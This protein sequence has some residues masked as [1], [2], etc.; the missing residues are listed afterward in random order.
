MVSPSPAP[1]GEGG[2]LCTTIEGEGE[3][4]VCLCFEGQL[5]LCTADPTNSGR[6]NKGGVAAPTPEVLH[7]THP[8]V[9]HPPLCTARAPL[10]RTHPPGNASMRTSWWCPPLPLSLSLPLPLRAEAGPA[11]EAARAAPRAGRRWPQQWSAAIA[12]RGRPSPSP[13]PP[14]CPPRPGRPAPP[15]LPPPAPSHSSARGGGND[16]DTLR[17]LSTR[18]Q[19]A[20]AVLPVYC[21]RVNACCTCVLVFSVFVQECWQEGVD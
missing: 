18:R 5:G 14:L 11:L 6:R 16:G 8:S 15:P 3:G 2:E 1:E 7:R 4:S 17:P 10:Y 9:P 19:A 12:P 13:S 20:I 21:L